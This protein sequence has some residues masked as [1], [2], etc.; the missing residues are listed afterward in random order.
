MSKLQERRYKEVSPE[1]TVRKLKGLLKDLGIE[2]EERWIDESSVGTYSLRVTVK[3][4]NI[5]QN[6]K[7][8]TKE[9]AMASGY[10]EFF[11]RFQNGMFKFRIEKP[12]KEIPFSYVPDEKTLSVEELMKENNSF[13]DYI[14]YANGKGLCSKQDKIKY[15]K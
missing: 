7:G 9:F 10:A 1:E 13:L 3:G 14:A 8:M 15:I 5:G 6:G 12:T 4:T 11:E 2:V